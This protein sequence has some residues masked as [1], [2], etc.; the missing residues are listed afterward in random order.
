MDNDLDAIQHLKSAADLVQHL[1]LSWKLNA[2]IN[3]KYL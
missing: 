2:P 3:G 1:A